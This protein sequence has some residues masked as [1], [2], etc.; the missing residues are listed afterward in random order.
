MITTIR[1]TKLRARFGLSFLV[2]RLCDE[3]LGRDDDDDA[4]LP[5]SF[6][7]SLDIFFSGVGLQ[8]QKA[9]NAAVRVQQLAVELLSVRED[10]GVRQYVLF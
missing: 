2:A 6:V 4:V 8:F 10:A 1:S 7:R 9:A 5:F 3:D